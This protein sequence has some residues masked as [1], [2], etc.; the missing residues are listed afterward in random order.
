[1]YIDFSVPSAAA[2]IAILR[3]RTKWPKGF[4]WDYS[5]SC[6]CALGLFNEI[7]AEEGC[8]PTVDAIGQLI[9]ITPQRAI[10]AFAGAT[11]KTGKA[12]TSVTPEDV[13]DI[14]ELERV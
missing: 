13:A 4:E 11:I 3:D 2:G 10:E 5:S 9:G 12:V 7:W 6:H 8:R 1:M 14:L